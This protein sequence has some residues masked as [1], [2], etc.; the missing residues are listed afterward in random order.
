MRRRSSEKEPEAKAAAPVGA[1]RQETKPATTVVMDNVT[2]IAPP[3]TK[4]ED[5]AAAV[6]RH[7]DGS[8]AS[9][10]ARAE[11]AEQ[12]VRLGGDS[13]GRESNGTDRSGLERQ[14]RPTEASSLEMPHGFERIITHL[15]QVVDGPELEAEYLDLRSKLRFADQGKASRKTYGELQDELNAAEENVQ[16]AAELHARASAA[17]IE[18]EGDAKII[19][20][21]LRDPAKKALEQKK[22]ELFKT[23]GV[24]GKVISNDDIEAEIA[25]LF[26]D[27]WAELEKRRTRAK[28]SIKLMG[29]L[30]EQLASRAWDLRTMLARSRQVE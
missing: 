13:G 4:L 5:V 27:E 29:D 1:D 2:I 15:F 8:L 26:P 7:F 17:F 9:A 12:Q 21:S 24:K 11:E 3:G 19:L 16:R 22:A 30:K 28:L 23:E 20:G 10:M 6:E 25:S 14:D 18:F